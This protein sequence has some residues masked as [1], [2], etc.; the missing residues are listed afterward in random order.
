MVSS[1]DVKVGAFVLAGLTAM[2]TVIFM[3][4]D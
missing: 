2:G 1:K 3:I 4:G